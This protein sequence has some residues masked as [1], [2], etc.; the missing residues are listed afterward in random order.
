[1]SSRVS[2]T[3]LAGSLPLLLF[4]GL[5]ST[6]AVSRSTPP[7]SPTSH[8]PAPPAAGHHRCVTVAHMAFARDCP[9]LSFYQGFYYRRSQ[10]GALCAGRDVIVARSGGECPIASIVALSPVGRQ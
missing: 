1:M 4:I 7:V 8:R 9:A 2:P 10:Q 5:F 3:G 6:A